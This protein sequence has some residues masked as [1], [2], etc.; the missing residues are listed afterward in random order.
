MPKP[1]AGESEKAYISR[2]V[3][4]VMKEG[5]TQNQALGQCYGMFRQ[6]ARKRARVK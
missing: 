3:K 6:A 2:C 5:K 1:Q 4:Y